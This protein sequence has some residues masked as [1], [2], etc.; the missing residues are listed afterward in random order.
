MYILKKENWWIWL[1]IEIFSGFA[2]PIVLAALLD[3]YDKEAWYAQGKNWLIAFLC[4][5]FPVFIMAIVFLIYMTCQVAAKL[6]VPGKELYLSPYIWIIFMII[7]I[8][9]WIFFI[10]M[11]LYLMI[12]II[13]MLY[14]G[15]GEK[16][17]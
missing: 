7:P 9:G 12:D 11:N 14:K 1:L 13:I 8:I 17:I 10:V 3:C 4:L 5:V 15:K 6:E 2:G 16:Y